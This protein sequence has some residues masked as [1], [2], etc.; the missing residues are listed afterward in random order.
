MRGQVSLEQIMVYGFSV[1][2]ITG[3]I[4]GL[5]YSGVLSPTKNVPSSC[6]LTPGVA[7]EDFSLYSDRAYVFLRNGAQDIR[8]T[9]IT[10]DDCTL[11]TDFVLESGF[12]QQFALSGCDFGAPGNQFIKKIRIDYANLVG[13]LDKEMMGQ[14]QGIVQS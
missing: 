7:C 2:V 1:L 14:V 9:G 13:G 3:A 12:G 10:I 6:I 11:V 8:I 4:A 5:A